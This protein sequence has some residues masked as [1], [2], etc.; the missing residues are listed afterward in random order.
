MASVQFGMTIE[1]VFLG[2]TRHAAAALERSD[3]GVLEA[4]RWCDLAL[5]NV[6][7]LAEVVAKIGPAPLHA[8]I[9]RGQ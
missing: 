3:I 6:D 5:W 7:R 9:W 2:M 8:R 4:G 1:E